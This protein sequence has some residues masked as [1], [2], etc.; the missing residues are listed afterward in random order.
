MVQIIAMRTKAAALIAARST[1]AGATLTA[2]ACAMIRPRVVPRLH[3]AMRCRNL[4]QR[5]KINA[6]KHISLIAAK[7]RAMTS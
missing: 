3:T 1:T 5:N 4:D 6:V 2:A 7:A